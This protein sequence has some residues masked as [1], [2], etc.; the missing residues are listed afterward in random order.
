MKKLI[1]SALC[2]A[3]FSFGLAAAEWTGYVSDAACGAAN[4]NDS[5]AS[6][7]CAKRCVESGSPP[8]LVVDGKVLA[9]ANA[10]KVKP[11]V[12]EKV[13]VTGEV[14]GEK[15]TIASIRRAG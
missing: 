12:G 10:D 11:H 7:E 14:K 15:I 1:V 6:K 9:I 4:A 2:S 13:T 3:V 5:Q 8:V